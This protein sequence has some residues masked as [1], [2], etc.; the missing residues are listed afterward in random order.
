VVKCLI[1]GGVIL[2]ER[3]CDP[4][5][6]PY[7]VYTPTQLCPA[8]VPQEAKDPSLLA[9][10]FPLVVIFVLELLYRLFLG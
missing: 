3:G 9:L 4:C 8:L 2:K 5:G 10:V 1:C 7:Q 6:V